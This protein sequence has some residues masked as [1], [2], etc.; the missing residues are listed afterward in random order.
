MR[1]GKL[2]LSILLCLLIVKLPLPAQA[3]TDL[4]EED[5]LPDIEDIMEDWDDYME[6]DYLEEGCPEPPPPGVPMPEPD[7][8]DL[9][10][11]CIEEEF[12]TDPEDAIRD[13]DGD[14][15]PD[16]EDGCPL[17]PGTEEN[18]GC[19]EEDMDEDMD[20]DPYD[21]DGD[22]INDS[23]DLCPYEAG[24]EEDGGCPYYDEEGTSSEEEGSSSSE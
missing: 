5:Y 16:I 12:E 15:V 19:P 7:P 18:G 10:D 4:Y 1:V 2:A 23:V 17:T 13:T 22:G 6:E 8:G 3:D 24:P 9:P 14:G 20:E 11:D 21:S